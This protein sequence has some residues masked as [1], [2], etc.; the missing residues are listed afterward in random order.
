MVKLVKIT[1]SQNPLPCMFL[2]RV[3]HWDMLCKHWEVEGKQKP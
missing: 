2:V 1:I 3:A